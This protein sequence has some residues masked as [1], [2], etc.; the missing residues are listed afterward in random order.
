MCLRSLL[1]WDVAQRRCFVSYHRSG[2]P[3]GLIFKGEAVVPK[4]R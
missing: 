1:F 4:R 3:Y 2:Q